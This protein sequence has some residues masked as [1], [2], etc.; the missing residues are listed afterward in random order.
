MERTRAHPRRLGPLATAVAMASLLWPATSVAATTLNARGLLDLAISNRGPAL[1][2]NWFNR[3]DSPFDAYRLRLF[4]EGSAGE[5]FDVFTQFMFN[6]PSSVRADG[7]YLSWTPNPD[8]D[9][10]AIAGKIPWL[11]G[12]YAPR[13]YSNKN[14]LIGSPLMYQYHT[15]LRPDQIVPNVDSLLRKAGRGQYGVSYGSGNT[16]RGMPIVYDACWNFGG[17]LSGSARPLEYAAGFV[18]GAPSVMVAG[19]DVNDGKCVLGRLGLAPHPALRLGVSG[20][21]GPYMY[22]RLN[23][24]M[25]PGA[26]ATDFNQILGMADLELLVGQAELRAEGYMNVWETPTVGDLEVTGG[27]VEGRYGLPAG[28]YLAGRWE[29][30]LF[31]EVQASSGLERP[32]NDDVW[33]YEV[34][35]GYRVNRQVIAKAIFQRTT[36]EQYY[37]TE[38][39]REHLDLYAAQ[40]SVSFF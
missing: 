28:F 31:G 4:I 27:Y 38:P 25:P 20:A 39:E 36:Y 22:D 16:F 13:T 37:G 10:H 5:H 19:Q 23:P 3:G 12:T 14:P 29:A 26:R 21:Y 15:T 40:L 34:G 17:M 9:L 35:G 8:R 30:M 7:A 1:E 32:W 2:S 33:R 18:S 11:I 6:D 24:Q